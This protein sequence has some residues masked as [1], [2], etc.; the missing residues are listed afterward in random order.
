M[1]DRNISLEIAKEKVKSDHRK[2]LQK[3]GKIRRKKK[4]AL[5]ITQKD[6]IL[7]IE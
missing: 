3:I 2:K 7:I 4:L 5:G 1:S 6:L